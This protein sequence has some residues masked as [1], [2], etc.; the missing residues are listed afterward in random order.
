MTVFSLNKSYVFYISTKYN[1]LM[2]PL[3][4]VKLINYNKLRVLFFRLYLSAVKNGYYTD[5]GGT[6]LDFQTCSREEDSITCK[7]KSKH[8]NLPS[9][10]NRQFTFFI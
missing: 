8:L 3:N 7:K 10:H 2:F 9:K 4:V 6:N 1:V 5:F